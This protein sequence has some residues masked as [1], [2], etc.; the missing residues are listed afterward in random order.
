MPLQVIEIYFDTGTYDNIER[1]VKVTINAQLGLIGGTMGLLTGFSILSAVEIV[2]YLG[3]FLMS[4]KFFTT[5]R[6]NEAKQIY[7]KSANTLNASKLKD[8]LKDFLESSTIHGLQYISRSQ[9]C[10]FIKEINKSN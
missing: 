9:V 2:Y 3:R 5:V 8:I 6:S 4:A 7:T 10:L 1:D